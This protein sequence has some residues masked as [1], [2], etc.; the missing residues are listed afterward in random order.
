[1]KKTR[2]ALNLKYRG[3]EDGSLRNFCE[4]KMEAL[5][6]VYP[7]ISPEFLITAIL[8]S[9]PDSIS[10]L[11]SNTTSSRVSF[12]IDQAGTFDR[13]NLPQFNRSDSYDRIDLQNLFG[14]KTPIQPFHLS[15]PT[16]AFQLNS[17]LADPSKARS[18]SVMANAPV[19]F[20]NSPLNAHSNSIASSSVLASNADQ[21]I[22]QSVP[23]STQTVQS[24][25]NQNKARSNANRSFLSYFGG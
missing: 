10:A 4:S 8:S 3:L 13:Q 15:P 6:Y 2:D 24:S 18:S 11:L 20:Q 16:R 25:D 9:M 5:V 23:Q 19:N 21:L 7:R 12:L 17:N 14:T 22:H 1:M